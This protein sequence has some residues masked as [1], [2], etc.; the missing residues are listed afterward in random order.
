MQYGS[1]EWLQLRFDGLLPED[2]VGNMPCVVYSV[3]PLVAPPAFQHVWLNMD[4]DQLEEARLEE[5]CLL[6]S[7][8]V[9]L[10][11]AD[12]DDAMQMEDV[13][14]FCW[15]VDN[16]LSSK[17]HILILHHSVMPS[18]SVDAEELI[19]TE[20]MFDSLRNGIDIILEESIGFKLAWAVQNRLFRL[21]VA[22]SRVQKCIDEKRIISEK[23]WNLVCGFWKYLKLRRSDTN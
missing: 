4:T 17:P 8:K 9:L 20:V 19:R 5:S 22:T 16:C 1:Q 13:S 6:S 23:T 7:A 21:N 12:S 10:I 11:L 2:M 14:S 18:Q 15:F 3:S